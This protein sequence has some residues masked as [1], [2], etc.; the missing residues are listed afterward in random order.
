MITV[1]TLIFNFILF[2]IAGW[3]LEVL[4]R[5]IINRRFINPGFNKG[6]YVPLYGVASIVIILT[7]SFIKD[8]PLYIRAIIYFTATTVLEYVTG[9]V[10]LLVFRRRC[11]DYRKNLLNFRGHICLSFSLAWVA[12]SFVFEF[13]LYPLS[14]TIV[15][16]MQV[17]VMRMVNMTFL[18]L[19]TIDVF[20]SS[21]LRVRAITVNRQ[22]LDLLSERFDTFIHEIVGIS[23]M[24]APLL[25]AKRQ[26]VKLY[27][28]N[29]QDIGLFVRK[30][31]RQ[32]DEIRDR[33]DQRRYR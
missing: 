12:A 11:W 24:H 17:D 25:G 1:D 14:S 15:N 23:L 5:S 4:Y 7:Y 28:V 20:H 13:M 27:A 30:T 3:L 8:Q 26:L 9:E 31:R 10:L 16:L 21:D 32:I 6:P 2:S 19:L 29:M 22:L 33:F 18:A